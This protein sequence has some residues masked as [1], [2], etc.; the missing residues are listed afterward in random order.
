MHKQNSLEQEPAHLSVSHI[1]LEPLKDWSKPLT[2]ISLAFILGVKAKFVTIRQQDL[3]LVSNLSILE[4]AFD[5]SIVNLG[6]S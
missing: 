1:D 6:I 2:Q 3:N 5:Q 4:I